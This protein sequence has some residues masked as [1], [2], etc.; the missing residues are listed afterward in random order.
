MKKRRG[1]S[2]FTPMV[3]TLV[4]MITMLIVSSIILSER[5]AVQG[6]VK[7]Y[8]SSELVNI[9]AEAQSRVIEEVRSAI[10]SRLEDYSIQDEPVMSVVVNDC[11]NSEIAGDLGFPKPECDGRDC[12]CDDAST[13]DCDAAQT[14]WANTFYEV[15]LTAANELTSKALLES[16]IEHT[17]AGIVGKYDLVNVTAHEVPFADIVKD[18]KF[19]NCKAEPDYNSAECMDGRLQVTIDFSPLEDKPI[20]EVASKGKRLQ[21]YMPGEERIYT[22]N[23]PFMQYAKLTADLFNRFQL[24]DNEW[25]SAGG[26]TKHDEIPG[27]ADEDYSRTDGTEWYHYRY[28]AHERYRGQRGTNTLGSDWTTGF[29]V[30]N[31]AVI[32]ST[33]SFDK[34]GD[35][36]QYIM[37]DLIPNPRVSLGWPAGPDVDAYEDIHNLRFDDNGADGID[38]APWSNLLPFVSGYATEG[39]GTGLTVLGISTDYRSTTIY[40]GGCAQTAAD[41]CNRGGVDNCLA[42]DDTF[43]DAGG[44]RLA[45]PYDSST[46]MLNT[47]E[48]YDE[49]FETDDE[50]TDMVNLVDKLLEN[51]KDP[52]NA[53]VLIGLGVD[54]ANMNYKLVVESDQYYV[55]A[56]GFAGKDNW[57]CG[58]FLT[59][60]QP[61]V[62]SDPDEDGVGA[63]NVCE[64]TRKIFGGDA[65]F[66]YADSTGFGNLCTG[67]DC[68][69]FISEPIDWMCDSR[70]LYRV[71]E[72]YRLYR[73]PPAGV[74]EPTRPVFAV[75]Y[76]RVKDKYDEIGA[77]NHD[78][79]LWTEESRYDD[80]ISK[81][82]IAESW[83]RDVANVRQCTY[84]YSTYDDGINTYP[85]KTCDW[86]RFDEL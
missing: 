57:H 11:P 19:L 26:T 55:E 66:P 73:T 54:A 6:S 42:T 51:V 44:D 5:V 81:D 17:I 76:T 41:E 4:I 48:D 36:R 67:T 21:V 78:Y 56:N 31:A 58:Q 80:F 49:R 28:A 46:E 47:A 12:Y 62:A 23:E 18:I 39:T 85:M 37:Q 14:C 3:G 68:P 45:D 82:E 33:V 32:S 38:D 69:W 74:G 50:D 20:A 71:E 52:A 79:T 63:A 24:L 40:P 1:F 75:K 64:A 65:P 35:L 34:G 60:Y 13:D 25:H 16:S 86:K 77:G 27:D 61:A 70:T 43:V 84:T 15:H 30:D 8:R 83:E 22:T 2:V 9:A 29:D 72:I 7:S 59:I 10:T 53:A